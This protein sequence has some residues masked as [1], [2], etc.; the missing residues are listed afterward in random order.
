MSLTLITLFFCST[1]YANDFDNQQLINVDADTLK[2]NNE[3][4]IGIYEGHIKLTQGTRILTAEYAISYSNKQ[5]QIL[6][7]IAIGHPAC[8]QALVFNNRPK[9]I[10]T[11][12]TIY[13][14]PLKDCLE[15]VGNAQIIQGRNHFQ[16]PQINYDFKKKT[17][18]SPLSKEGHTKILLAPIQSMHS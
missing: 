4:H 3:T 7:I 2:F 10:A 6:K 12:D 11:G 1:T 15:A 16:G 14:Y 9:L 5:G 13:Y 17:V 8:Y 18:G